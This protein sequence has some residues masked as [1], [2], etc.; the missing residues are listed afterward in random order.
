MPKTSISLTRKDCEEKNMIAVNRNGKIH[1]RKR[2]GSR[3][4]LRQP[5]RSSKKEQEMK[6]HYRRNSPRPRKVSRSSRNPP[7]PRKVSRSSRSRSRSTSREKAQRQDDLNDMRPIFTDGGKDRYYKGKNLDTKSGSEILDGLSVY[8]LKRYAKS[9]GLGRMSG[10]NRKDL[11]KHIKRYI[12][13]NTGQ[14]R[15]S[16]PLLRGYSP[17]DDSDYDD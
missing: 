2:P 7:R 15:K 9:R 16:A 17:S 1:C 14:R 13:V 4:S 8:D 12:N 11:I 10:L 6:Q 5:R 3:S